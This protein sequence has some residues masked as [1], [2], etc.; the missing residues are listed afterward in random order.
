MPKVLFIQYRPFGTVMNGGDQGTKKN[1][2]TLRRVLGEG[3]VDVFYLHDKAGKSSLMG[4]AK[5]AM[6]MPFGYFLGVTPAKVKE[7]INKANGY[8][9]V[10]IER[11][12]FGILA[13]ALKEA[14]YAGKIITSFQNI[15]VLY[16]DAKMPKHLPFRS[17]L[18]RL[19]DKND[20][21]SC[22]HSDIVIALNERD[23]IEL[24]Q[25][26]NRK[27]DILIPVTLHDR[28]ADKRFDTQIQTRKRP[29]CLFLG[30]YFLANNEGILWFMRN[31]YPKVDVEVKI[32]GR[33]MSKLKKEQPEL[34]R[35]IE[36]VSDAP[37]LGPYFEEADVMVLPIFAGSGMKVKTC[38]S[39]MYGK[40]IIATD[41]ALEGYQ[42]EEGVSA[43]RC[44]TA[45]EFVACVN[46]F[47]AHPRP[48][49]N[50]KAR[51]CYLDHYSDKAV[52]KL[53][54]ELLH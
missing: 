32:V 8:A 26:Y 18:L 36:V 30:S 53:F 2:D 48:R 38:E 22:A 1:L 29:L 39:L 46:N 45:E 6:L 50:E 7:L 28:C 47:A 27:A 12:I 25:R 4:Y 13:K 10:F 23:D 9:Y 42:I 40:N 51:Q 44:N 20:R 21:W 37:D 17:V 35:D 15:E 19:A 16:M 3:N 49:W 24:Q 33:G 34:L 43:W 5:G 41:E 54:R 14:G 52:E 31:V 11:S